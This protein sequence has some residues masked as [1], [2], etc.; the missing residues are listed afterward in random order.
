M[1]GRRTIPI[2]KALCRRC[3]TDPPAITV[4]TE[5][6]C[7]PCFVKYVSTKIVKRMES[8][9]VRHTDP[10]RDRILLLPL[11]FGSSSTTLL[12]T[13]SRHL[14]GQAE[15]TG[16]TGFRLHVLHVHLP[17]DHGYA[18]ILDDVARS[19]PDHSYTTA[20]LKNVL[21]Q[22]DF[23]G[24]FPT[25]QED[26]H[27]SNDSSAGVPVLDVLLA[28]LDSAT[29]RADLVQI[30]LR[31]LVVQVAKE[32]G[33]EAVLWGD[34]TT[35]LAER[36][37]AETAKGR[38]LA[39]PWI[40]AD[41]DSLHGMPFYCPMRDLLSKEITSFTTLVDPPLR[42]I[43]AEPEVKIAAS[44]K[45]ITIDGLMKQYFESV[46]ED[47]PSIV[48]NVVKTSGKLQ[49]PSLADIEKQCELCDMPLDGQAP[50]RSRL[51]YACIRTLPVG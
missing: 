24:L 10:G 34:S 31:K 32:H 9:R 51:C 28:R 25:P 37:L 15:K 47:Y 3:Q 6:L 11:S 4:R 33:C 30:L 2:D 42:P 21:S 48:A 27:T 41:G 49:T 23:P 8:F 18:T 43:I 44:T 35:R 12:H 46:E 20:H 26:T 17:E 19:Y 29:S 16:R 7:A 1:P 40:A 14:Q 39:V 36:T 38:G 50:E 13:L 22:E 5:P 45:S